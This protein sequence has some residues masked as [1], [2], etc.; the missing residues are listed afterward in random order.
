MFW[1]SYIV[2]NKM[3]IDK[4]QKWTTYFYKFKTIVENVDN[5][6]E[7]VLSTIGFNFSRI[8]FILKY[9]LPKFRPWDI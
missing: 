5:N 8:S 1:K 2:Y 6:F 4:M 9:S 7:I 3:K